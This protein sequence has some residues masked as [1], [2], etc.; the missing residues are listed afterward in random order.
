MIALGE[1]MATNFATRRSLYGDGPVGQLNIAMVDLAN[2]LQLNAKFTGSGGALVCIRKDGQG[3][4][5]D[6]KEAEAKAAYLE[7]GF[8]FIRIQIPTT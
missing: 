7:H 6:E 1:L 8:E 2:T 3:W 4:M 5:S